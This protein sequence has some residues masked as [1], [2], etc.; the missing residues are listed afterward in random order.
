MNFLTINSAHSTTGVYYFVFTINKMGSQ[1]D[2]TNNGKLIRSMIRFNI[3][4]ATTVRSSGY[5]EI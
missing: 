3:K 1:I 2:S 5:D 4:D